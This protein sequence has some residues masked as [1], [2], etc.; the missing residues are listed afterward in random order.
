[1]DFLW[2]AWWVAEREC[3]RADKMVVKKGYWVGKMVVK[4]GY[5]VGKM[6]VRKA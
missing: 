3:V 6:V 2:V 5:W 1:M 4:K